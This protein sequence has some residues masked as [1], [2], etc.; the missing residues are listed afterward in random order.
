MFRK[1][2]LAWSSKDNDHREEFDEKGLARFS[3]S[4]T[5]T[6]YYTAVRYGDSSSCNRPSI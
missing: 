4:T 5:H 1:Q 6:S 3:A 2:M